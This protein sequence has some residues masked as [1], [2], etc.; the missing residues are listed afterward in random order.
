MSFPRFLAP[1]LAVCLVAL[2]A[3]AQPSRERLTVPT[4][5]GGTLI[6][7][8]GSC[9]EPTCPVVLI[10]SGS[11]GFGAAVYDELGHTFR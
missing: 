6:E 8:F 9:M 10:L 4:S 5:N 2:D 1:V 3:T 7:G 11:R